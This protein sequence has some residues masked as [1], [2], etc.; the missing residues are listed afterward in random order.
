MK[1]N[2]G[3]VY[4]ALNAEELKPGSKVIVADTIY[5]MKQLLKNWK[6]VDGSPCG[7]PEYDD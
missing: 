7:V 3:M 6:F 2:E 1:Y 5:S 4:T